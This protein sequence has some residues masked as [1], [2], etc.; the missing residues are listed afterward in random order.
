VKADAKAT[1]RK[2]NSKLTKDKKKVANFTQS[3][4]SENGDIK[5]GGD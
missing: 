3:N 4:D 1:G 5:I 2:N